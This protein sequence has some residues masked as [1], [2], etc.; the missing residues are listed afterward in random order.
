MRFLKDEEEKEAVAFM[1]EAVEE[2]KKA[3]CHEWK[4]GSVIV[5]NGEVT[6]RGFNSPAGNRE[7]QRRCNHDKTKLH[8]KVSDKSCCV[9]A[10]QRA[11]MDVLKRN[12]DKLNGAKIY[13]IRL[14]QNDKIM[15][16]GKPFCTMCSKMALDAGISEFVLQHEEGIA[17]YDTGEYNKLSYEYSG[18]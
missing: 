6:G 17:A 2:A 4:C 9:H 14:D 5:K 10:E 11:I 8:R 3:T 15:P 16:A 1:K 12:G 13:F 7:E 18:E